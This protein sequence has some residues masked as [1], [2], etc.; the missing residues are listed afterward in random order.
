[1]LMA[2]RTPGRN[3]LRRHRLDGCRNI[4]A[5]TLTL[6]DNAL[7]A[8]RSGEHEDQYRRIKG[9]SNP[10]GFP[11]GRRDQAALFEQKANILWLCG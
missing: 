10:Q 9:E 11:T 2:E 8:F 7:R 6:N 4:L 1:M 3:R 5:A